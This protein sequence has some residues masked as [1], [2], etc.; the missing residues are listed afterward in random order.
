VLT[1]ATGL[2]ATVIPAKLSLPRNLTPA[3]GCR[4]HT[5]S[6]SASGALVFSTLGVHRSPPRERDDRDSPLLVGQDGGRC[7]P[8][9]YFGKA[10]YFFK[11]G[12]TGFWVICPSGGFVES[13][14]QFPL[15]NHRSPSGKTPVVRHCEEPLRRS[16]PSSHEKKEWIASSLPP[17]L[18]ELRRTSRSTHPTHC[19]SEIWL[20]IGQL[21]DCNDRAKTFGSGSGIHFPRFVEIARCEHDVAPMRHFLTGKDN[22]EG[23]IVSYEMN[24]A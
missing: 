5:S 19:D 18:V 10:E 11:K 12:L 13:V 9:C 2:F 21:Q 4:A 1:S 16:N 14:K 23:E 8:I 3:S 17:S 24:P 22:E 6:P 20:T 7:R 15:N